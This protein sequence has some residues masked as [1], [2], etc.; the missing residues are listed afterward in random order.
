VTFERV[1]EAE[2]A[3]GRPEAMAVGALLRDETGEGVGAELDFAMIEALVDDP[4][5]FRQPT[6]PL[7]ERLVEMG[8]EQRGAWWGPAD[9][10]WSTPGEAMRESHL[11]MAAA[12][13]GLSPRDRVGLERA[14]DIYRE[15]HAVSV[16]GLEPDAGFDLA[17]LAE[18]LG[19]G[20]L[21]LAWFDLV[22]PSLRFADKAGSEQLAAEVE[23]AAPGSLGAL[24]LR[25][26]LLELSGQVRAAEPMYLEVLR[27]DPAHLGSMV[28]AMVAAIDASR[29]DEAERLMGRIFG[30]DSPNTVV[31]SELAAQLRTAGRNEPCPCGS[32]RKYKQCHANAPLL[33]EP[34]LTR[35]VLFK[36]ERFA[37]EVVMADLFGFA[38]DRE[39]W[40]EFVSE[41]VARDFMI[42][43]GGLLQRFIDERIEVLPP[44]ELD[45]LREWQ[46]GRRDVYEVV[47]VD[48]GLRLGL[49]NVR[50]GDH[51]DVLEHKGSLDATLGEYRLLRLETRDGVTTAYGA[52]AMVSARQLDR[53]LA[54][55]DE[56]TPMIEELLEW[57]IDGTRPPTVVDRDGVEMQSHWLQLTTSANAETVA[58]LFDDEFGPGSP[59][60]AI[61]L[62][63]SWECDLDVD[64]AAGSGGFAGSSATMWLSREDPVT[65]ELIAL[66]EHVIDAAESAMLDLLPHAQVIDRESGSVWDAKDR[67]PD[68]HASTDSDDLMEN[69]EVQAFLTEHI[70]EMEASW[71]D[72]SIPALGGMTPRA[73]LDDPTRRPD[74]LRLLNTMPESPSG[75]SPTRL[76]ALLG[77]DEAGNPAKS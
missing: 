8:F 57:F 18:G 12:I 52:A 49:R 28:R 3:D 29:F 6:V 26:R 65:I 55:L 59:T 15:W 62:E 66:H 37:D 31:L 74:L 48:P 33:E 58:G 73:A 30:P 43:E 22:G 63:R 51:H 25:A 11:D 50:T 42:H 56:P 69:P 38:H 20:L 7:A 61:P 1:D 64:A 23:Q 16:L 39:L 40:A 77:I 9:G 4:E 71:I 67:L 60:G 70:R 54:I 45:R 27:R 32:G 76:R 13:F 34:A 2:L 24:V 21:A 53:V 47:D 14:E 17:E 41:P 46:Q 35:A 36:V 5:L 68:R 75:F 44:D 10:E 72:E 19:D